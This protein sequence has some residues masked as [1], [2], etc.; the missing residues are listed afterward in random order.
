VRFNL[1]ASRHVR[2]FLCLLAFA[3]TPQARS[4]NNPDLENA[5]KLFRGGQFA[6]AEQL[7]RSL[8]TVQPSNAPAHLLLGESLAMQDERSGAIE[9]LTTAVRLEPNSAEYLN[10][11]GT[12]LARFLET[13]PAQQAF[14]RA[15]QLD[16]HLADAHVSL[17]LLLAQAGD[18]PGAA[19]HFDTAIALLGSKPAAALPHYLRGK[20]YLQQNQYPKAA[21]EFQ[22]A[23]RV[24]PD[25][26]EAWYLLG[27]ARRATLDDAGALIAFRH[28]AEMLPQDFNAQYEL[29]SEYLSQN[30]PREAALFLKKAL[31][32]SPSDW[33]TLYKLQRALRQG[34]DTAAANGY[35][36]QL[37]QLVHQDDQSNAHALEAKRED[38][39]GVAL[40]QAG[41]VAGALEKYRSA[42]ELVPEQDGYRLNFALAL[43]RL[44]RWEEGIAEIREIVRRDPNNADA[45]RALFI[46]EDK[47]RAKQQK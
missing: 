4:Q 11:L 34:G 33:G 31:A 18:L 17:A 8:V 7:L 20:I 38:D 29:G 9:E 40:E 24:R 16:P 14:T 28:A 25:Y 2:I 45:Q 46:A 32:I 42:T 36:A 5:R 10:T 15:L 1:P 39:D 22:G 27:V 37:R 41:N 13:G 26:A 44:G 12:V 19:Q 30:K 6:Q 3:F 21:Q 47:A 35:D 23:L 43:C